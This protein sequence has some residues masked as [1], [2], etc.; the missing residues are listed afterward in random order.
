VV[1]YIIRRL[2]WTGLVVLLVTLLAFVIFFVL[3][4]G[5]PATRFA[6]RQAT[7][8]LI[9][10]VRKDLNLDGN[11]VE[12]YTTFVGD[13]VTGDEYGW[14]GLGFSFKTREAIKPE[15]IDRAQVTGTLI[16]GGALLWLL[17]GVPVGVLAAVRRN[18]LWDRLSM[19]TALFFI[20]A[21]VFWLGLLALYIFWK[22]LELLPGTGYV[23]F[24]ESPGDWFA[25]MILPWTVLALLFAAIYARITR[26]SMIDVLSEDYV[27]TA[28]AK[29]LTERRVVV[30]HGLRAG[31]TP[32]VTL[33]A[34]D[35]GVLV[36]GTIVTETVFNLQGLG[37]WLL[38]AAETSDL[39]VTLAV[40]VVVAI[41]VSL[42]ALV[43]DIVYALLDPR[44][45]Y[46]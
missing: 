30:R 43:A 8:E 4:S 39:P 32:V 33:L 9:E 11:V 41:A 13:L 20:S 1:R 28:R 40:T 12:Q 3:P 36:G 14:P 24:S 35:L 45:R 10:E 18:T 2:L 25:H 42:L 46:R 31:I 29:G 26:G 15:L 5:D 6:G 17:I 37:N 19:G 22:Q 27:R 34:I 7:P 16:A 38:V 44:V 23:A 21:P